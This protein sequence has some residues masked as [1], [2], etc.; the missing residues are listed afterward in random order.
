M[1]NLDNLITEILKQAQEEA[2]K[3]LAEAKL[4]RDKYADVEKKK[5][6]KEIES[7]K[8]KA[9]IEA[10]SIKEKVLSNANLK[11]RDMIL[12]AKDE[13]TERVLNKVLEKLKDLNREDY[14]RFV[15]NILRN[16]KLSQGAEILLTEKMKKELG[17]NILGYKISE[18]TVESGCSIRDGKVVYNNEFSNIIDFN[19]EDLERE[20][21]S[22]IFD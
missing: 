19:R 9:E 11:T 16:L 14:L 8:Q 13:L 2:E 12:K 5:L 15:E 7:I 17:T 10:I 1:S 18:Q 20:I 6:D 21:L 22:K 3:T 4:E